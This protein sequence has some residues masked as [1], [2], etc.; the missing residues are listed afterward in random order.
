MAESDRSARPFFI[1][2]GFL[3]FLQSQPSTKPICDMLV[4]PAIFEEHSVH[5]GLLHPTTRHVFRY[6][7]KT[8]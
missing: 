2:V 8:P 6:K 1:N 3:R 5:Y 4:D 7:G